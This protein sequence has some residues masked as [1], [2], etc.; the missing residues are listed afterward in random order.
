MNTRIWYIHI[1]LVVANWKAVKLRNYLCFIYTL[2]AG[3]LFI[4]AP[5]LSFTLSLSLALSLCLAS[6]TFLA[7]VQSAGFDSQLQQ[8]I[9]TKSI[10]DPKAKS[11]TRN[12]QRIYRTELGGNAACVCLVI[13]RLINMTHQHTRSHT[14]ALGVMAT[15]YVTDPTMGE[16]EWERERKEERERERGVR[17]A[18][19]WQFGNV[20]W[21]L[22]APRSPGNVFRFAI[23]LI[24]QTR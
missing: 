17:R 3:V 24:I 22:V 12:T 1:Q 21:F 16:G 2:L 6:I 5:S 14:Q 18:T 4:H 10:V 13:K 20:W 15:C 23:L 19:H 9:P 11:V 7:T 8:Q